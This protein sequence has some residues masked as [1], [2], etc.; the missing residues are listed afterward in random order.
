MLPRK[1]REMKTEYNLLISLVREAICKNDTPQEPKTLTEEQLSALLPMARL[2]KEHDVLPIVAYALE[3]YQLPEE[4]SELSAKLNKAKLIAVYRTTSILT[5]QAA[6]AEVL[7]EAG[8]PF[9]LLKGAVIRDYYPESWMRTSS[10]I[11]ILLH[12]EDIEGAMALLSE[13]LGYSY[14]C[15]SPHDVSLKAPSGVHLELH[16]KLIEASRR[17]TECAQLL[18]HIW[19]Y[20]VRCGDSSQY[21]LTDEMYYLYHIAHMAKHFINGGCGLRSFIDLWLMDNK[22]TKDAEKRQKLLTEAGL[23]TFGTQASSLSSVWLDG[24]PHTDITARIE[25][26]ILPAG[27]YGVIDNM[28]AVGAGR[29]GG[30]LGYVMSRMFMPYDDLK[31]RYPK[32]GK[33]KILLPLL[34]I[35]R[36]LALLRPSRFKR[37][38][39]EVRSVSDADTS[40]LGSAAELIEKLKI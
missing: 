5:E 39:E 28:V 29:K 15:R 34:H 3:S 13:K 35:R 20:T 23:I 25:E 1:E 16:F 6:L 21:T 22:M 26:Y 36:W 37:A 8:I 17:L 40:S 4:Y 9:V 18:E 14:F 31:N 10:D 30:K 32:M 27:V 24:I 19:D 33:Y 38:R 7:M 12:R 11:D 2:A